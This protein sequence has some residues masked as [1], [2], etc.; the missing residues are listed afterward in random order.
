M[1]T[2]LASKFQ[3]ELKETT[4]FIYTYYKNTIKTLKQTQNF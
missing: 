3:Q 1:G 4:S 2:H